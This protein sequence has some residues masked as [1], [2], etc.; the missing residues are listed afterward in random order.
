MPLRTLIVDDHPDF[1]RRSRQL[2]EA[3]GLEVVAE[4]SGAAEGL[5]AARRTTPDVVLL[6]VH[7]PDALGFDLVDDFAAGDPA[8]GVILISTHDEQAYRDRA[9][10]CGARGFISKEELSAAA[11]ERLLG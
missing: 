8:P 5:D 10:R 1:R 6:D 2:L 11:V 9:D 3:G 7:L 4:A